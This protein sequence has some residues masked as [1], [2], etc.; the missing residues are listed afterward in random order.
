MIHAYLIATD[1][2]LDYDH[3]ANFRSKMEEINAKA[4]LNI[5]VSLSQT[6]KIHCLSTLFCFQIRHDFT[7]KIDRYLWRCRKKCRL[8]APF[9]GFVFLKDVDKMPR[10]KTPMVLQ[11]INGSSKCYHSWERCTSRHKYSVSKWESI[12]YFVNAT[13]NFVRLKTSHPVSQDPNINDFMFVDS[14]EVENSFSSCGTFECTSIDAEISQIATTSGYLINDYITQRSPSQ[15]YNSSR[16]TENDCIELV[17][18]DDDP[19]QVIEEFSLEDKFFSNFIKGP[20]KFQ[21]INGLNEKFAKILEKSIYVIVCMICEERID[22]DK[23]EIVEHL[24][25]HTGIDLSEP[26]ENDVLPLYK[27]ISSPQNC[28]EHSHGTNEKPM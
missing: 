26:E 24:K 28:H 12:L 16:S 14:T 17:N 4:N 25:D 1:T 19:H 10:N 9:F 22:D 27:L 7:T 21:K 20:D 2:E 11:K 6:N 5:S 8:M 3:C 15:G 23:A 13:K 18:T